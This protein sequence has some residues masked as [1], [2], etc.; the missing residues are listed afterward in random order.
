MSRLFIYILRPVVLANKITP[1][2]P[3]PFPSS[4]IHWGDMPGFPQ[5][6]RY[7][8]MSVH[9]Y[10]PHWAG[11][12]PQWYVS[13]LLCHPQGLTILRRARNEHDSGVACPPQPLARDKVLGVQR[14]CPVVAKRRH[15]SLSLCSLVRMIPNHLHRGQR[16]ATPPLCTSRRPDRTPK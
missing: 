11:F 9:H 8:R 12:V 10:L 4:A 16:R 3:Q 2:S 13:A 5:Y 1:F 7:F 15:C 6:H 14:F